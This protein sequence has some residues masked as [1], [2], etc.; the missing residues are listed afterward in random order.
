MIL[1]IIVAC[2]LAVAYAAIWGIDRHRWNEHFKKLRQEAEHTLERE[3]RNR[4]FPSAD[5]KYHIITK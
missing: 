1:L 2:I 4:T 5:G 3:A